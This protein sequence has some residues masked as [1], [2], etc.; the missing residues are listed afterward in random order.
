MWW[1][2][3][4]NQ[5]NEDNLKNV[6]C[7]ARKHFRNKKKEYLEAKSDEHE[8]NKDQKYQRLVYVHQ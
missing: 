5:S 6:T 1:L 2:Q 8:T 4:P 3:D 7:E